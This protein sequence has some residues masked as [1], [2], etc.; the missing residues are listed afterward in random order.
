MLLGVA[1]ALFLLNWQCWQPGVGGAVGGRPPGT[2]LERFFGWPA[3]Y[4]AELWRSDDPALASRILAAAPFFY[5][6]GE[7]SLEDDA[8]GL[9]AL[10]VDVG[11]A[12]LVLLSA[13]VIMECALRR[14][15]ARQQ[16]ALLTG[17]G[18]LL[19]A[20]WAVSPSISVSL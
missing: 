2:Q 16:V 1:A 13:A 8:L 7:M 12:L 11:F 20:L 10:A 6:R 14:V 3:T 15:W 5:P 4:K 9:A 19:V 18:L 17:A